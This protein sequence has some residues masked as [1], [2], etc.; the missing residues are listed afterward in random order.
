MEGSLTWLRPLGRGQALILGYRHR[1]LPIVAADATNRVEKQTEAGLVEV[2]Y[3]FP[4]FAA[5]SEVWLRQALPTRDFD[6]EAGRTAAGFGM[7]VYF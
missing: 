2:A 6:A 1:F 7:S 3:R 4:I 5:T